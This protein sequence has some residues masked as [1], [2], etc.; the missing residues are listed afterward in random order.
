MLRLPLT[1][2]PFL[3]ADHSLRKA[4]ALEP[5]DLG[6]WLSA[7]LDMGSRLLS[8]AALS[9]VY[10]YTKK[11]IRPLIRTFAAPGTRVPTD[12]YGIY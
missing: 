8:L 7:R 9:V 5:R 11:T 4:K 3:S 10:A 2:L 1:I 12:E 6:S